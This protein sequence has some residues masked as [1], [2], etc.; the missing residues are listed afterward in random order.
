MVT[1]S[2]DWEE[3]LL[4]MIILPVLWFTMTVSGYLANATV[5]NGV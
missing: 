1:E 5:Q 2:G 4:L 3:R